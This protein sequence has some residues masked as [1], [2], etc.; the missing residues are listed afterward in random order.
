MKLSI[1]ELPECVAA[2]LRQ[3]AA[4]HHRSVEEEA[5]ATLEA[6]LVGDRRLTI[7]ELHARARESGLRSPSESA[8][9]IREDRDSDH[10]H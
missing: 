4:E 7:T 8:A 3:R 10:H 6:A 9:I 1:K 5:V 2:E